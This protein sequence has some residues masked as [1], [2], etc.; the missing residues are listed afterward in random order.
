MRRSD[1][2]GYSCPEGGSYHTSDEHVVMEVEDE[3]GHAAFE[4]EGAFLITDLD[5]H[6]MPFIR[7]RNGDAGVRPLADACAAGRW[8]VFFGS[9]DVSMTC[10]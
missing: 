7:Y 4:R 9:T 2:V 3:T 8:G 1:S 6:A 10:W 5:N